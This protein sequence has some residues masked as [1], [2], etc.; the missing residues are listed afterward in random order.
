[1]AWL[2]PIL[3]FSALFLCQVVCS[4][5]FRLP[6]F[7]QAASKIERELDAVEKALA[8][9]GANCTLCFGMPGRCALC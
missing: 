8:S 6:F 5:A 4:D 2:K 7:N 1:M 3:L 9:V